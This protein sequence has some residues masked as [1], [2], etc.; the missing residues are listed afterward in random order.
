MSAH[1]P[2]LYDEA[3]EEQGA[4][5]GTLHGQG[6]QLGEEEGAKEISWKHEFYYRYQAFFFHSSLFE[7]I[8]QNVRLISSFWMKNPKNCQLSPLT[9]LIHNEGVGK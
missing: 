4:T 9:V 7:F 1:W 5:H 6:T 3:V 2:A 8:G